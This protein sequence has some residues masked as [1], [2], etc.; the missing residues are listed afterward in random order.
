MLFRTLRWSDSGIKGQDY[1][2][3]LLGNEKD[4]T[5]SDLGRLQYFNLEYLSSVPVNSPGSKTSP[6]TNQPTEASNSE[7]NLS[8]YID[9]LRIQDCCREPETDRAG[10]RKL[11]Q[12]L[13]LRRI[14]PEYTAHE[15]SD[16]ITTSGLEVLCV[17]DDPCFRLIVSRVLKKNGFRVTGLGTAEQALQLLKQRKTESGET[18]FPS[19]IMMD[20]ILPGMDGITAV[21]LMRQLYPDALVP[22]I[23]MSTDDSVELI[24][25]SF[26]VGASDHFVKPMCSTNLLSRVMVQIK[27]KHNWQLQ[28]S[29]HQKHTKLL[30][31]LL[32][33]EVVSRLIDGERL[34]YDH[35]PEVTILFADIVNYTEL[36]ASI[37]TIHLI[38]ILNA[39]FSKFDSLSE[40]H[41]VFKIE[42]IGDSYMAVAGHDS[43]TKDDHPQRM[44]RMA[45]DMIG[46]VEHVRNPLTQ[47]TLQIRVGI[48]TGPCYAGV[49]GRKMP[50]YCFFGDTINT[51]SRMEST[52]FPGCV[53]VT[54]A[55]YK[56]YLS[57][58]EI[59]ELSA[60]V[61]D[62]GWR[63]IKGKGLMRAWLFVPEGQNAQEN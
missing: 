58:A 12:S 3:S 11:R 23:L 52:G 30:H 33:R 44:L 15:F 45:M 31:E 39:V 55:A 46:T 38:Q 53:Q 34:I 57:V 62:L 18:D 63:T 1:L 60:S 8:V 19:V 25:K 2:P 54:D 26:E 37:S 49:V 21:R 16:N 50:R 40:K 13:S 42:T 56:S 36:A 41:G 7:Q 17:D 48:H 47:G 20:S 22:I 10:E 51:A 14:L 4:G 5:F 43:L 35:H 28:S 9:P 32:P 24:G 27:L 29:S 59:S 6:T 61:N